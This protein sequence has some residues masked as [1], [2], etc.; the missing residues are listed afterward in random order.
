MRVPASVRSAWEQTSSAA[1]RLVDL[2]GPGAVAAVVAVVVLLGALIGSLAREPWQV[3][4]AVLLLL[5]LVAAVALVTARFLQPIRAL[6]RYIDRE[7]TETL[8]GWERR[9]SSQARLPTPC[10][11]SLRSPRGGLTR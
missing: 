1:R 2:L 9:T 11:V 4:S 8:S 5:V 7:A 6:S 10:R 3:V